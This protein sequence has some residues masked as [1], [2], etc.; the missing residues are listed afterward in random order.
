MFRF[1]VF[2]G[3][4][5]IALGFNAPA[6]RSSRS[7]RVSMAVGDE[8]MSRSLPFLLKPKNLEAYTAGNEEFDPLGFAE[9]YDIKW[10]R[11]AELKHAR[12]AML[13]TVGW[14]VQSA[15]VH[16]PSPDGLYDVSNPID[17]FFHVGPSPILQ[18]FL[19]VGAL[20][21][22]NHGGKMG[23]MD[24]HTGD[25]ADREV[26]RF[27]LPIYGAKRLNGKSAEQIEE[28]KT[29]EIRNGRLAMF[30]T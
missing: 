9:Y 12:V 24:M 26:G 20:E 8:T 6:A 22:I 13:A 11:E 30:G 3:I 7:A 23:M 10:M 29:K 27:E 18:I 1:I 28:L 17:A 14:L 16:L 21:S 19:G 4:V 15:G 5:A 2:L 25:G